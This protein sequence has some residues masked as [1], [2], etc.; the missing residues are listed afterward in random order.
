M[1]GLVTSEYVVGLV[2]N[3]HVVGLVTN[4]LC[5]ATCHQVNMEDC[6]THGVRSFCYKG[7]GSL[8]RPQI[9]AIHS[10]G[11]STIPVM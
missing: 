5:T 4:K 3:E 2:T 9:S 8:L 11:F 6:V 7:L 10:K 1:V